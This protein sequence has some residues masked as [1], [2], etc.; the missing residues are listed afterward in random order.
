M[1]RAQS[2]EQSV[3]S[4]H[5]HE[6]TRCSHVRVELEGASQLS[7]SFDARS[8]TDPNDAY[9]TV[10]KDETYTDYWGLPR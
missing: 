7:L 4:A 5:P 1:T 8:E 9:V 10:Y 2:R 3:E 6:V